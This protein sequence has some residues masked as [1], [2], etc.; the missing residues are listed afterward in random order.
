MIRV[1]KSCGKEFQD[2]IEGVVYSTA[3]KG[4]SYFCSDVCCKNYL[5]LTV[6]K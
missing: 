6:K 3:V 5:D 4:V 2:F 1:C